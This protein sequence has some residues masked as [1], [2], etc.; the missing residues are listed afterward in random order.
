[1]FTLHP[2]PP[3]LC[4]VD[5]QLALSPPGS[6]IIQRL[7]RSITASVLGSA[8]FPRPPLGLVGG[9]S[10][11]FSPRASHALATTHASWLPSKPAL[12]CT[13]AG[14]LRAP[15]VSCIKASTAHFFQGLC[16]GPPLRR[17][18]IKSLVRGC[19]LC[20]GASKNKLGTLSCK[21]KLYYL[22]RVGT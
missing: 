13:P 5:L 7:W 12:F 8:G 11:C 15:R 19:V 17:N 14:Q 2:P 9:C 20:V 1:M 16:S 21:L 4:K 22:L 6:L 3:L 10:A 18:P